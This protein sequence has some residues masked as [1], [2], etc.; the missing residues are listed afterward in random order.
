VNNGLHS[1]GLSGLAACL[2]WAGACQP[3][4]N[5]P[6]G[7]GTPPSESSPTATA[8]GEPTQPDETVFVAS[9]NDGFEKVS[10]IQELMDKAAA[11][12][13]NGDGTRA[14]KNYRRVLQIEPAHAGA[15]HQLGLSL[16][17][18]GQ[19]DDALRE[20]KNGMRRNPGHGPTR[21]A[22][23]VIARKKGL[24]A[25]ALEAIRPMAFKGNPKATILFA[26]LLEETGDH[27][28]AIDAYRKI[29]RLQPTE[30]RALEQLATLSAKHGSADDAL[31][32]YILVT[33]AQPKN[34]LAQYNIAVL[35]HRRGDLARAARAY[36]KAAKINPD[37]DAA[38]QAAALR[39]RLAEQEPE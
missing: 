36:E 13:R 32:A 37:S 8:D 39:K 24:S 35:Y 27:Q 5:T 18:D 23:A 10:S 33:R 26:A 15:R 19:E 28:A 1:I 12:Q 14:R 20:F 22:F 16:W 3:V 38:A 7:P 34:A 9:P 2:L 21:Q 4:D 17:K 31:A 6:T 11:A 25:D 29:A 30:V